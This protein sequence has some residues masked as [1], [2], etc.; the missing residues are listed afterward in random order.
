MINRNRPDLWK[1]DTAASVAMYNSWFMEAAPQAYRDTRAGAIESIKRAFEW[2]Q[3]MTAISPD[4]IRKNPDV[5][6]AL[7]MSTAPPL[8]VDRLVGLSG[9]TKSFVSNLEKGTISRFSSAQ[10][11]ESSLHRICEVVSELLDRDL[12]SW[13]DSPAPPPERDTEMAATVV[14]DRLCGAIANPIVRNAQEQRQLELIQRWLNERGY[15][16]QAYSPSTAL[17]NLAALRQM[18][19]GTFFFHQNVVVGGDRS[20]NIPIDVVIQP[21]KPTRSGLPLLIEAKSA[22]DFTNTNKRRK[23]EAQKLNQLRETYG[24]ISLTLFL[25][26]YFDGGYLGYS[27]A[28]GLDWVWEHRID[29]LEKLG[30]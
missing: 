6:S 18:Q 1:E 8:A 22:G 19:P 30:V 13:L 2:S 11:V 3:N 27:A 9:V 29:D 12:F 7:R 25:C 21:F 17:R 5:V 16:K 14:A 15:M 28:E 23:E 10:T 4:L 20:V 24:D 26:G